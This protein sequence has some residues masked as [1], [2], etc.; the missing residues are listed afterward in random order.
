MPARTESCPPKPQL[1]CTLTSTNRCL[2]FDTEV[3]VVASVGTG[4]TVVPDR[5]PRRIAEAGFKKQ[6]Q[7]ASGGTRW[8]KKG[9]QK[10]YPLRLPG[11]HEPQPAAPG[12]TT[13]TLNWDLQDLSATDVPTGEYLV[14]GILN[15]PGSNLINDTASGEVKIRKTAAAPLVKLTK[16]TTITSYAHEA[17]PGASLPIQITWEVDDIPPNGTV[18]V[19]LW[20]DRQQSPEPGTGVLADGADLS[21]LVGA[22]ASSGAIV[23][24]IDASQGAYTWTPPGFIT[25]TAGQT[26]YIHI[27]IRDG[28]LPADDDRAT[29]VGKINVGS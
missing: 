10:G 8:R 17:D 25:N 7:T 2:D 20:L 29:A 3:L 1:L 6:Q 24:N 16:P 12:S 23:E 21:A 15:V 18:K 19:D 4:Q 22:G 26:Y 28:I 27:R 5:R 14:R 9:H 11:E 13:D